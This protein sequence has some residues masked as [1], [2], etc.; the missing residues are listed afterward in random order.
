MVLNYISQ[1]LLKEKKST[2]ILEDKNKGNHPY[3]E[4]R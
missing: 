2:K 4:L 1:T 3:T